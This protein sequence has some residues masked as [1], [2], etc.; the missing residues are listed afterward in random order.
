MINTKL[1]QNKKLFNYTTIRVGGI[2][3]YFA[4]PNT[5]IELINL[6]NWAKSKYI[7]C[8]IVGAGSNI[9]INDILLKG[10]VICTKKLKFIKVDIKSG[11]VNTEC[12][13]MLPTMANLLAK[14]GCEGGEWIIGIPGTI[15][16][17]I[18]MNAG[19]GDNCISNNLLSV[20]VIDKKTLKIFNLKKSELKFKYRSSSLQDS[21]LLLLT[22]KF[23]FEPNGNASRITAITRKNLKK[24]TESQPY[25]LPSFGSVFKNPQNNYAG[26]LIEELGLK[27]LTIGGAQVSTMHSNFIVNYSNATSEDIFQLITLIQQKVL[28]KKGIFLHPEVRMIGY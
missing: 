21:N 12:G 27:G 18:F 20:K 9:L 14:N 19:S 22:A 7:Q 2:A 11:I 25:H 16:G 15:G 13:V 3:E 28:Q 26:K 24:K 4:E 17:A 5:L 8:Q 6:I 1:K 10:L 23:A